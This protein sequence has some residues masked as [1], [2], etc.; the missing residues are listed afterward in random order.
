[1]ETDKKNI[2][3][4]LIKFND[5]LS[6]LPEIEIDDN[7]IV[8]N[9]NTFLHTSNENPNIIV[10]NCNKVSSELDL[11][12][13]EFLF[14]KSY[15]YYNFYNGSD[16]ISVNKENKKAVD[17]YESIIAFKEDGKSWRIGQFSCR[18]AGNEIITTNNSILANIA[19]QI[20]DNKNYKIFKGR[21]Y[22]LNIFKIK[23]SLK[24][25]KDNYIYTKLNNFIPQKVDNDNIVKLVDELSAKADLIKKIDEFIQEKI[26]IK[27]V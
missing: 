2:D 14:I 25:S 5:N 4:F 17:A 15:I 22:L 20:K 9:G 10:L 1:M 12:I 24:T 6:S 18:Q 26:K 11:D 27:E 16:Y 21:E 23:L 3:N 7:I 13:T 19:N 8:D